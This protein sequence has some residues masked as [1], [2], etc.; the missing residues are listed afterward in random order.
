MLRW[1]WRIAAPVA[2]FAFLAYS[3]TTRADTIKF[4]GVSGSGSGPYTYTFQV[5]LDN[6][7]TLVL[8]PN[9]QTVIGGT[10]NF[11]ASF[12]TLYD[13]PGLTGQSYIADQPGSTFSVAS[14][15]TGTT[16][17]NPN[18]VGLPLVGVT[19]GALSNI[20]LTF[21]G[22]DGLTTSS[23]PNVA[24]NGDRLLGTLSLTTTSYLSSGTMLGWAEQ[25]N[26]GVTD[27]ASVGSV[28]VVV[29]LPQTANMGI[30]LIVCLGCFGTWRKLKDNQNAMA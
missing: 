11:G 7:G 15:A 23:L 9:T 21:T 16:P 2:A 8:G 30:A 27:A 5:T 24:L 18:V 26:N 28:A 13:I 1:L 22:T 29:P 20:T 3:P 14:A 6:S 17:L 19:D 25:D 10:A 4:A 12:I